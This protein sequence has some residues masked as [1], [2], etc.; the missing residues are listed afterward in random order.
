MIKPRYER[1]FI[2][3]EIPMTIKQ[4][5]KYFLFHKRIRTKKYIFEEVFPDSPLYEN[6]PYKEEIAYE[7]KWVGR[8][9]P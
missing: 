2:G 8:I 9:L 3:K 1:R 5:V 6:A 7:G 4:I